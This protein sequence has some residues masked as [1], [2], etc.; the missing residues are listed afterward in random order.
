MQQSF[1]FKW[2]PI[3][4]AWTSLVR[5]N[6]SRQY[7]N[8]NNNNNFSLGPSCQKKT[9]QDNIGTMLFC[10]LCCR[11]RLVKPILWTSVIR[12]K[13]VG[14]FQLP[15]VIFC[16]VEWGSRDSGS[17]YIWVGEHDIWEICSGFYTNA[18]VLNSFL[19]IQNSFSFCVWANLDFFPIF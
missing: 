13:R 9:G 18:F 10:T 3:T 5:L 12:S 4:S 8:N 17:L 11:I 2:P 1:V 15:R 7:Q 19:S 6:W 16:G 14:A